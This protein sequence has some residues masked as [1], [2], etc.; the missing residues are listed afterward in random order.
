MRKGLLIPSNSTYKESLVSQAILQWAGAKVS[1]TI[2]TKTIPTL[3]YKGQPESC[4]NRPRLINA[5]SQHTGP[6]RS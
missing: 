5:A 3:Y 2:H 6:I 4:D 1:P